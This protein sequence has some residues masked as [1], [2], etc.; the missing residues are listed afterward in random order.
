MP[1]RTYFSVLPQPVLNSI[2][3]STNTPVD[4]R[5]A[6]AEANLAA[7]TTRVESAQTTLTG[8]TSDLKKLSTNT[9][10]ASSEHG[11]RLA[12]LEASLEQLNI[13]SETA[14]GDHESRLAALESSSLQSQLDALSATVT[15]KTNTQAA[16]LADLTGQLAATRTELGHVRASQPVL[17]KASTA[18]PTLKPNQTTELAVAWPSPMPHANYSVW[19][20]R[21]GLGTLLGKFDVIVKPGTRTTHGVTLLVWTSLVAATTGVTLNVMATTTP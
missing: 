16:Q 5:L 19:T 9:T 6:K 17:R 18:L 7:L 10:S 13:A 11:S 3:T 1:D 2:G 21:E 8:V 4:T 15:D 14:T 12:A 20:S